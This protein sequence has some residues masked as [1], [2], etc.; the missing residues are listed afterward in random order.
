M[1]IFFFSLEWKSISKKTEMADTSQNGSTAEN[2]QNENKSPGPQANPVPL[3]SLQVCPEFPV[4]VSGGQ[5]Y[6]G[7]GTGSL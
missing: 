4:V 2:A 6:H 5:P 3:L 1:V 7:G